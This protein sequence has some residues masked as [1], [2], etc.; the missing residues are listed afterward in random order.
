MKGTLNI[1]FDEY[2]NG[3][4]GGYFEVFVNSQIRYKHYFD[5]TDLFTTQLETGDIVTINFS[6]LTY[7][8]NIQVIRKDFTT[9]D[10]GGDFG[11]KETIVSQ[12]TGTNDSITFTASTRSDS[13]RFIYNISY[14]TCPSPMYVSSG[15]NQLFDY[16]YSNDGLN[17]FTGSSI[18]DTTRL[19][20]FCFGNGVWVA[21]K[22]NT[23]AQN[24]TGSTVYSYDGIN[25]SDQ[26]NISG[27]TGFSVSTIYDGNQFVS[28]GIRS[29]GNNPLLT[30][31]DGIN[32]TITNPFSGLTNSFV[33]RIK[34][35]GT[36]YV[37]QTF[38]DVLNQSV[39]FYSNDL[40]NWTQSLVFNN[41]FGLGLDYVLGR[42]YSPRSVISTGY[43]YSNDG[44]TWT[45]VNIGTTF[46][47]IRGMTGNENILLIYG[48]RANQG[49]NTTD[50]IWY[51]TNSG[52]TWNAGTTPFS[53]TTSGVQYIVNDGEKFIAVGSGNGVNAAYSY[54][55]INWS[56][57]T[58]LENLNITNFGGLQCVPNPYL[59][60]PTNTC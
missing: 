22:F 50:Q 59:V 24:T 9:D 32:W 52:T 51:S 30:S 56:V 20:N 28:L 42:F 33:Q 35:D 26:T 15:V 54:D 39:L 60:P 53:G 38:D 21:S 49:T 48:R 41:V 31:T 27:I 43:Y 44:I 34:Y 1:T 37:V 46:L 6:G 18:P 55:G 25:W 13:Y 58:S 7:E 45:F 16:C 36:N 5:C 10:E 57:I 8:Y 40:I 19:I 29:L 2:I 3:N 11:I 17:W 12:T 47:E 4:G 14:V 23:T